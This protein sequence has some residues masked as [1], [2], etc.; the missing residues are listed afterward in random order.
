VSGQ[1]TVNWAAHTG[2]YR[3]EVEGGRG[4]LSF[5]AAGYNIYVEFTTSPLTVTRVLVDG[6]PYS[7]D[8]PTALVPPILYR[9]KPTASSEPAT[10]YVFRLL[11]AFARGDSDK[12]QSITWNGGT[13]RPSTKGKHPQS[14]PRGRGDKDRGAPN[15]RHCYISIEEKTF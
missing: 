14:I 9:E 10:Q 15:R 11:S 13:S 7:C 8:D 6:T 2:D 1:I 5:N 4:S 12:P 3:G